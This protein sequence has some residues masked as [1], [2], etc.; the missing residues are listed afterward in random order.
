MVAMTTNM[1]VVARL[2]LAGADRAI[3]FYQRALG[4][5][6]TSRYTAPNGSVVHAE[7]RVGESLLTLKDEDD[8]DKSATALGGS[9]VIFML[10]VEDAD[11]VAASL[12]QAG[13]TVVIPVSDSSYGYR[14]GRLADPFGYQ[15]MVSQ[16]IEELT[17]VQTQERLDADLQ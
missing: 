6:L 10:V 3:D 11:A 8:M 9:P 5:E 12:L 17:D 7:L 15:W 1:A 14:Q 16:D 2:V 4:A 13:A